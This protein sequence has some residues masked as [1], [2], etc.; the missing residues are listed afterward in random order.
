MSN[1][2]LVTLGVLFGIFLAGIEGT[3][4]STAMPTVVAALGGLGLYSWVF[5]SY[6]L[7]AAV[8]MPVFGKLA[9]IYGR[10]KAFVVGVG[11]FVLGSVLSGLAGSMVQLIVFR[12][13]QG[14]GGGA[15]FAI[16]YTILGVVYPPEMR[17]KAMGFGS[18]VWGISSVIGPLLGF[19]LVETLGW[20]WVFYVSVPVGV[21]A[22][23]LVSYA[24]E[25]T[26]GEATEHVDYAGALTLAVGVGAVLVG[27]QLV[28]ASMPP[29]WAGLAFA[30][31]V[32]GLVGF[33]VVE[34]RAR[35]PIL[36]PALFDDRVFVTTNAV[37]FLSS[38]AVF[39]AIAYVPLFVQSAR[40]GAGSAALAIF[41]IS[42][43]WSGTS[44]LVGRIVN[45]VGERRLVRL[46]TAV[47]AASF[48][49][50]AGWTAHTPIAVVMATMFA[51]G[52]GM[53]AVTIPLLT[54]IQN[55]FGTERMGIATSS[56]Q[57]FRNLGGTIGVSVLG[58]VMTV[59]MRDRLSGI[60]GV[61]TLGDL[62]R[63]LLD[64]GG[65]PEDL[66]PVLAGGLAWVFAV[67]VG[68][69]LLALGVAWVMPA[70]STPDPPAPSA[71][72]E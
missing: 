51:L 14:V 72:D 67:S 35:E 12:A 8:S 23:A 15:M 16:P 13:I 11:M 1:R 41:P 6:M 21:V 25:E 56:Q 48:V 22:V 37:G 28:E 5:A 2:R 32:A 20:R 4:V 29:S 71:T 68:V 10:K 50:A 57:F 24:L 60:E 33:S 38:F 63:L 40:G 3:V 45:T 53:G 34:H 9:D 59:T 31:G 26:T 47:L 27:F 36:A 66:L 7:F 42:L 39:A 17:G 52:V 69:C 44:M 18:A 62:R 46:G 30:V 43:G 19:A 55:H 61:S 54:M 70:S 65:T 49:A 64:A 58:F